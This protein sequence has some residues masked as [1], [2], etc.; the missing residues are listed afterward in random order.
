M[1]NEVPAI[2]ANEVPTIYPSITFPTIDRPYQKPYSKRLAHGLGCEFDRLRFGKGGS[3]IR[4]GSLWAG[5]GFRGLAAIFAM[6]CAYASRPSSSSGNRGSLLSAVKIR[7]CSIAIR[8]NLKSR[9]GCAK[10]SAIKSAL[11]FSKF[12]RHTSCALVA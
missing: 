3:W 5:G 4:E 1:P 12:E 8:F 10:F 9:S 11:R 2:S 7:I 6:V